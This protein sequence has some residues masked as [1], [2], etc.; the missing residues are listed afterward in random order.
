MSTPALTILRD[1][2]NK[3]IAVLYRHWDGYPSG[4]GVEL[5]DFLKST[6]ITDG[7]GVDAE[8][9]MVANGWHCLAAQIV[10]H[11]KTGAGGFYLYAP[12][13]RDIG[14]DYVYVVKPGQSGIHLEVCDNDRILYD[15]PVRDFVADEG[16][17]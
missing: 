10:A 3:D 12:G 15:G 14:E 17:E 6:N 9:G 13:T 11:F 5:R 7:I 1:G 8:I 16:S 4:H 2:D